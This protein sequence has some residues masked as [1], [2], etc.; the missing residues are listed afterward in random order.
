MLGGVPESPEEA[1]WYTVRCVF[2]SPDADPESSEAR[3]EERLTMW[4][5]VSDHVAIELAEA[6]AVEHAA[7][8]G[9][10]Y[11]GLAQSYRLFEPPG[12]G[13]E[14]YSLIRGSEL[15]F[16]DY[17][18]RF[19]DTGHELTGHEPPGPSGSDDYPR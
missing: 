2:R 18:D 3:Y 13:T 4:R 17:I 6:E 8:A 1:H 16:G 11:L 5:A 7:I 10:E 19:F 9:A 15:Q 12:E 14:V